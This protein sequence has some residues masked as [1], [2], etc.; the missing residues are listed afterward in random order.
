[1]SRE[2]VID[3]NT[4]KVLVEANP[5][6]MRTVTIEIKSR[7]RI[8]VKIPKGK[9]VDV[10][11]LLK[12]YR[13]QIEKKYQSFITLK[14]M[15]GRGS[16]LFQGKPRNIHIVEAINNKVSLEKNTIEVAHKLGSD[17]DRLLKRWI[18]EQTRNLISETME[19]HPRLRKPLRFSVM[20][21]GRW[22]YARKGGVIVFNWQLS[23]LQMELA[24]YVILHELLHLEYPNHSDGFYTELAKIMPNYKEIVE[25]IKHY[26]PISKSHSLV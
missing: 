23:T 4:V 9:D 16:V 8:K 10:D 26:S 22:G 12:K 24:E 18:T 5:R 2:M 17:P 6:A 3:G 25:Q 21:T 13:S 20:D 7:N 19:K 14:P 15:A 1:M 11:L